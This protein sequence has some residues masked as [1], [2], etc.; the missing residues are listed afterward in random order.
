M[1]KGRTKSGNLQRALEA[2][3]VA[4]AEREARE[5]AILHSLSEFLDELDKLAHAEAAAIK[6]QESARAKAAEQIAKIESA[7][8]ERIER[9]RL[10]AEEKTVRIGQAAGE[11]AQVMRANGETIASIAAQSGQSQARVRELL[12]LADSE[13]STARDRSPGGDHPEGAGSVDVAATAGDEPV[14]DDAGAVEAAA[15][16]LSA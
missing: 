9:I 7:L 4:T 11:A 5:K 3:R 1:G 15:E 10:S 16:A 13:H 2:R 14:G 8:S 12:R 6:E